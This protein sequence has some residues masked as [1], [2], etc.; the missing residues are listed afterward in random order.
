MVFWVVFCAVADVDKRDAAKRALLRREDRGDMVEICGE[1]CVISSMLTIHIEGA[2][3][4]VFVYSKANHPMAPTALHRLAELTSHG[5]QP[6]LF[7]FRATARLA[8]CCYSRSQLCDIDANLAIDVKRYDGKQ[9][10]TLWSTRDACTV[11]H[12]RD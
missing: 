3:Q 5:S 12:S 9:P 2:R 7:R 4:V 10:P 1:Y 8:K 11:R 6:R